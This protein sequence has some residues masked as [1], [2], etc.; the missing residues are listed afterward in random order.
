[1]TRNGTATARA[2][3]APTT[4]PARFAAIRAR[5]ARFNGAF[6][7][8]VLTTGIYCLPSCPAR[9]ANDENV[10]FFLLEADAQTAGLRPCRRC[11][12]DLF[13]Q[14]R[15]PDAEAVDRVAAAVRR[16]PSRFAAVEDLCAAAGFGPTK[17]GRLF[18][19][20]YHATP[21]GFLARAR[22]ATACRLLSENGRPKSIEAGFAAGFDALSAF[23]E[24]FRH[25][26]G[27]TPVA[28][29]ELG[30]SPE[31]VLALPEGYRWEAVPAWL[32]RDPESPL[33][34][35]SGDTIVKSIHLDDGP[36]VLDLERRGAAVRCRVES[37]RRPGPQAM[38]QAHAVTVRL[39]GLDQDPG[40]F[41]RRAA[42]SPVYR[43]VVRGREGL[44]IAQTGS[45]FEAL[46][47]AIVGQQVN[48]AFA[49]ALRRA[50][51]ERCGRPAGRG[52]LAHPAPADVAALDL[53]DLTKARFSRRK[54]ETLIDTAR[55]FVAAGEDVEAL[56][57][58]PV[59]QIEAR[60]QG[61]RGIGP[62]TTQYVL[63]R[64]C[65]FAD[66]VPVGDT[67][68][69]EALRRVH[70]LA[71]RPDPVATRALLEP[72]APYRSLATIHLWRWMGEQP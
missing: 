43:P 9:R 47:W 40:P 25:G 48:L 1:M 39:L 2:P 65:A 26:T 68:L 64:G 23:H 52:L 34:R 4:R 66:C 11:R 28:Y 53:A 16:D 14:G 44:R 45:V 5:D 10:R 36:A 24:N 50:V 51:V 8:G 56:A 54:A 70:G 62:W 6:L 42:R 71:Q 72:L 22:V 12:P 69:G 19:E 38:R 30:V 63:L 37:A 21:A 58:G 7:T 13:Y 55:S 67:G 3:Q 32:G 29:R 46:T 33:E 20:R 61:L 15:D 59:P 49:G 17:L 60:L 57:Q 35:A 27:L 41:E 18:R 31:F